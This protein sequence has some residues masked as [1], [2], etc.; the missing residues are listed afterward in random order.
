MRFTAPCDHAGMLP[1]QTL[2]R[3]DRPFFRLL[4]GGPEGG[5]QL[6]I[7][8]TV[9]RNDDDQLRV[10]GLGQ[11]IAYVYLHFRPFTEFSTP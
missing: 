10:L 9:E 8:A 1:S 5:K 7:L 6:S 2:R 11:Y 3:S 4:I